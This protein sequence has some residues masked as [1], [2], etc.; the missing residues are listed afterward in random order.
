MEGI[1]TA[2]Q[3]DEMLPSQ[4]AVFFDEMFRAKR[5]KEVEQ[6]F[7]M[8]SRNG[9]RYR[10]ILNLIPKLRHLV[11]D[12]CLPLTSAVNISYLSPKEQEMV[13]EALTVLNICLKPIAAKKIRELKGKLSPELVEK[14]ILFYEKDYV[15]EPKVSI[16]LP[17]DISNR[18]FRGMNQT[19]I[20][21]MTERAL[22][23]WYKTHATEERLMLFNRLVFG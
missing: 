8:T 15:P 1:L 17:P 23:A 19:E 4:K 5:K 12:Y 22:A 6:D 3:V 16:S 2:R 21:K 14:T 13:Y 9:A 7:G 10:R 20:I 11:D 18:Y